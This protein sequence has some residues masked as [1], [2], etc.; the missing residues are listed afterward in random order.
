MAYRIVAVLESS[1]YYVSRIK[2]GYLVK[3]RLIGRNLNKDSYNY[4]A[5]VW[6]FFNVYEVKEIEK[7]TSFQATG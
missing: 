1:I 5:L 3:H 2:K 4:F 6:F 7:A